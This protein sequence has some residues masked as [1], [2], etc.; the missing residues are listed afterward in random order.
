MSSARGRVAIVGASVAM[1][2]GVAVSGMAQLQVTQTDQHILTTVAEGVHVLRHTGAARRGAF[3]GNTTVVIGDRDVLVVDSGYLPSVAREDIAVIRKWTGKPVRYLVNTHWH[4][5]H[6]WGNAAYAEAFPGVGVIAHRKTADG[7]AGYLAP[8]VQRNSGMPAAMNKALETGVDLD[9]EPLSPGR[10]KEI[11][12]GLA[13]AV[14]RAEEFTR[15][16][17]LL[18]TLTLEH[19][20]TLDLGNRPV[21]LKHFGKGNTSGDVIVWLP[22]ERVA[23][24]GDL[25][26]SPNPYFFGGFPAEWSRTLQRALD[27]GPQTVVPGHGAVLGGADGSAFVS[28]VRDWLAVVSSEVRQAV[29]QIGNIPGDNDG[30]K[31]RH[32]ERVRETVLKSAAIGK[33]RERVGGSDRDKLQFFDRSLPQ[34]IDAAY[35]EAWGD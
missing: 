32:F 6:T 9:G 33:L 28:L 14:T 10:R 23:V 16:S 3:S 34:I 25:V 11:E 1:T 31:R 2:L 24:M 18:P 20:L 12:S 13:A 21:V 19:E 35:R 15:V 17:M 8:M 26:V 7:M 30:A 5:D 29:Y 27:L 22:N 4:G